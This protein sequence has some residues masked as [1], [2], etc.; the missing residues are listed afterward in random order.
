MG[1]LGTVIAIVALFGVGYSYLRWYWDD[2]T[3]LNSELFD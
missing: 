2:D 1:S 3:G